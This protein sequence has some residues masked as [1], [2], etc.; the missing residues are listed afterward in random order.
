ML[1]GCASIDTEIRLSDE[2]K[3]RLLYS[4]RANTDSDLIKSMKTYVRIQRGGDAPP[5]PLLAPVPQQPLALSREQKIQAGVSVAVTAANA[6][7]LINGAK[8]VA[9]VVSAVSKTVSPVVTAI[10]SGAP[11]GEIALM[12]L[13]GGAG[14]VMSISPMAGGAAVLIF[15]G[16]GLIN[17]PL[18]S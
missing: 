4:L 15:I 2:D 17:G 14:A 5:D 18:L 6:Y 16:K 3:Q 11:V 10:S 12:A 9:S 13:K 1:A 7:A 8:T